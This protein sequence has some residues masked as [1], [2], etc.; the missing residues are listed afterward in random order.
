MKLTKISLKLDIKEGQDFTL[1]KA[2]LMHGILMEWIRPAYAEKLHASNGT[3]GYRLLRMKPV[4][5]SVLLSWRN[6]K[7][8]YT[9]V[10]VDRRSI[11]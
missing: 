7:M 9:F 11:S 6:H 3:G 1:Q 10:I 4:G 2:S 5:K 8:A